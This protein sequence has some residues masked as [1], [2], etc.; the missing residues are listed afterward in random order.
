MKVLLDTNV[1]IAAFITHGLC[2]DILEH[3]IRQHKLITSEFILNE[4]QE[5]LICKF[6]YD[7]AEAREAIELVR[8]KAEV[9]IPVV[10]EN[11]VCRDPDDDIILGTAIAGSVTCII[12]GDKD[13]L[14]L[15]RFD[16][17]DI[18][19]PAEFSR[20]EVVRRSG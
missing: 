18:V 16:S 11:Q 9:V 5:H 13:L 4:F 15:K 2:S 12:T 14:V 20:Y 3:C 19:S 8:L 6:K 10:L 7:K 1:L 17:V